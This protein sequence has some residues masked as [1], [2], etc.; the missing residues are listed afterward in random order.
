MS[1]LYAIMT[2]T[3]SDVIM[4][5]DIAYPYITLLVSVIALAN[6]LSTFD[7]QVGHKFHHCWYVSFLFH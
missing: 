1:Q 3:I 5:T 6:H 4:F 7:D 2:V